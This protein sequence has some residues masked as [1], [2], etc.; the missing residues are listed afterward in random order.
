M[1][2]IILFIVEKVPFVKKLWDAFD[3]WKEYL[4]GAGMMFS[5]LA[6]CLGIIG[7]WV[8]QVSDLKDSAAVFAWA[9]S[10]KHDPASAAIIVAWAGV[11]QGLKIVG[12]RHAADKAAIAISAA[13][14]LPAVAVSSPA[15]ALVAAPVD[16][17][18]PPVVPSPA[19]AAPEPPKP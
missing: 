19:P 12:S 8:A 5:G 11:L 6:G 9:Q 16:A 7:I 15:P 17:V 4:A 14:S 13:P 2:G 18:A 1:E 10:L 3:G